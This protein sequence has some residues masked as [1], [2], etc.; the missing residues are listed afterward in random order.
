MSFD[1]TGVIAGS[2]VGVVVFFMIVGGLIY[3]F[4]HRGDDKL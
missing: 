4:M 3:Y 1:I 2:V